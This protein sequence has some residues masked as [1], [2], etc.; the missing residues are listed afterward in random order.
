MALNAALAQAQTDRIAA[1]QR[2]AQS[3][4]ARSTTELYQSGTLQSLR[5]K[6]DDLQAQYDQNLTDFKPDPVCDEQTWS[7]SMAAQRRYPP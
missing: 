6:R 2:Y 3:R 5:Q 4:S 1:E 7:R